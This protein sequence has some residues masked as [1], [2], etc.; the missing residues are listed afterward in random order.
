M[1]IKIIAICEDVTF[2][3]SKHL[4]NAALNYYNKINE[5]SLCTKIQNE[6]KEVT[7]FEIV[8]YRYSA[9]PVILLNLAS[10]K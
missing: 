2:I 9:L 6:I 1:I 7:D 10:S 4:M 8:Q 3:T 5:I